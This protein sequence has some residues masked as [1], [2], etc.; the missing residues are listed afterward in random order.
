[1][2]LI[3]DAL[4]RAREAQKPAPPDPLSPVLRPVEPPPTSVRHSSPILPALCVALGLVT[5]FYAWQWWNNNTA[6]KA[7]RD[8]EPTRVAARPAGVPATADTSGAPA[9]TAAP[10]D[11]S[12]QTPVGPSSTSAPSQPRP[13]AANTGTSAPAAPA[14]PAAAVESTNPAAASDTSPKIQLLKLQAIV[15]HP[16]RPSAMVNGKFLYIGDRI[17]GFRVASITRDSATLV[18]GGKTNLLILGE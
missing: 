14:A 6:P 2:S 3:N 15:F 18:G 10:T 17:S 12:A 4:R 13:E 7:P 8:A 16:T 11:P 5:I 1:M 9:A